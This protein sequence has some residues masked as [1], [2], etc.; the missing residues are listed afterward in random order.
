M[1]LAEAI[2]TQGYLYTTIL[3]M[4][5]YMAIKS[6]RVMPVSLEDRAN[7]NPTIALNVERMLA[8]ALGLGLFIVAMAFVWLSLFPAISGAVSGYAGL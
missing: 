3:V 8:F 1:S 6:G 7:V 2:V 5:L 4:A